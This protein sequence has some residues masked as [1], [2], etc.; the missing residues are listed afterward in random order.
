[1]AQVKKNQLVYDPFVGSGGLLISAAHYDAY[2]MGADLDYNLI[3]SKG[4]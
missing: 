1:M 2:V 3:H 4:I